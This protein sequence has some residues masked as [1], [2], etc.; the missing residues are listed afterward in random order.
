MRSEAGDVCRRE[1]GLGRVGFRYHSSRYPRSGWAARPDWAV[2][3]VGG[4]LTL[5]SCVGPNKEALFL[6]WVAL[7]ET[8]NQRSTIRVVRATPEEPFGG[9]F[10]TSE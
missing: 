8:T 3:H 1:L 6:L 5:T 2:P 7:Q 10:V 9:T 4:R